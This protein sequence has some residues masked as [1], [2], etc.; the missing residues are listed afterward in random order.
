[1]KFNYEFDVW[2]G[3]PL[4]EALSNFIVTDRLKDRL[5]DAH[6]S[7]VAFGK[8]EVTE[9]GAYEDRY[10]PQD[11]GKLLDYLGH[12]LLAAPTFKDKTG[13]LPRENIDTTFSSLNE[14]LLVVRKQ[15]GEER[16]AALRA[17]H[18]G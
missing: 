17:G 3:D 7:G 13:Y 2:L 6:A 1:V 16:H 4:V 9:S 5:I 8:V 10:V 18:V 14:D 12:M 15:L 11:I